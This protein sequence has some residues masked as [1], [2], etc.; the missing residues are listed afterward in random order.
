MSVLGPERGLT[1]VSRIRVEGGREGESEN[2]PRGR[3]HKLPPTTVF[4]AVCLSI[5]QHRLVTGV[6]AAAL[7]KVSAAAA[8][9][10]SLAVQGRNAATAVAAA[11]AARS[12]SQPVL[13]GSLH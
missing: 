12:G 4:R 2:Q 9:G 1:R 5:W 13:A 6:A 11:A 7:Y 10:R 3:Q 8:F